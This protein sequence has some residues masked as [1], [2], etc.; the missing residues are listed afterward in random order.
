MAAYTKVYIVP[1]DVLALFFH[2][3][4]A[5]YVLLAALVMVAPGT[6][7]PCRKV[8]EPLALVSRRSIAARMLPVGRSPLDDMACI[9]RPNG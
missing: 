1:N 7:S 8:D 6:G 2:P 4:N 5:H 3:L 9:L